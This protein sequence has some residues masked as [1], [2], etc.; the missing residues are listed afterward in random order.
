MIESGRSE[1]TVIVFPSL[2]KK[3]LTI[4]SFAQKFAASP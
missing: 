4:T 1:V 3:P 2:F